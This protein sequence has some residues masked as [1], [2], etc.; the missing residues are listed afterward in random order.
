VSNVKILAAKVAITLVAIGST[1]VVGTGVAGAAG[2]SGTTPAVGHTAGTAP[3]RA[4]VYYH[5]RLS[6]LAKHQA[7]F[8]AGTAK[9]AAS[10]SAAQQ[11]GNTAQATH[12]KAKVAR[13]TA[14]VNRLK[15]KLPAWT[16]KHSRW[17]HLASTC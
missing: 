9:A 16:A 13:R 2:S 1:A 10:E 4:C 14:F 15:A 11:A 17:A 7:N 3:N 6:S 8:A 5:R 12:W